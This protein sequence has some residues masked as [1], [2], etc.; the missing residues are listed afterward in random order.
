MLSAVCVLRAPGCSSLLTLSAWGMLRACLFG[1]SLTLVGF[2][3]LNKTG[4]TSVQ[5][6]VRKP[7][8][9]VRNKYSEWGLDYEASI[10]PEHLLKKCYTRLPY[11]GA[12][13]PSA[14]LCSCISL[15]HQ[16]QRRTRAVWGGAA[17]RPQP[18]PGL[19]PAGRLLGHPA[20]PASAC[21]VLQCQ[22]EFICLLGR[23]GL[24]QGSVDEH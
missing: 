20:C 18:A 19:P 16:P 5:K 7:I 11:G 15:V 3:M 14:T 10:T 21:F 17:V 23:T 24:I 1:V 12:A 6:R 22:R 2:E 9:R 4:M 13:V 8:Q